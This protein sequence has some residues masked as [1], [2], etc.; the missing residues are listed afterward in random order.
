MSILDNALQ[1]CFK[2]SVKVVE[3]WTNESPD[4]SF[5]A[6]KV[7]ADMDGD[8]ALVLFKT[9]SGSVGRR[10]YACSTGGTCQAYS[11]GSLVTDSLTHFLS[12]NFPV[13]TTGVEYEASKDKA[14]TSNAPTT[15]TNDLIPLE[16]YVYKFIGGQ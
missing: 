14:G 15:T 9:T 2:E 6:Q 8:G 3:K 5:R 1:A 7:S 13:T 11:F 12:R 4:S 16:I 10:Y